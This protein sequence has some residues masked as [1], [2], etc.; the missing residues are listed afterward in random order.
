MTGNWLI[1]ERELVDIIRR[2]CGDD[3]HLTEH[4]DI[5]DKA[6]VRRSGHN[7]YEILNITSIAR[8][9]AD[10]GFVCIPSSV[11]G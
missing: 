11:R 1:L 4:G 3:C 6:L 9:L 8:E 5:G 7:V 2:G 10:R